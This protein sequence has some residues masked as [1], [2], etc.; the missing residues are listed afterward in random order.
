MLIDSRESL[1]RLPHRSSIKLDCQRQVQKTV[2]VYKSLNGLAPDYLCS[3]FV[4]R[5]NVSAYS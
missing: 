2:M 4:D 5:S 1:S 3:K